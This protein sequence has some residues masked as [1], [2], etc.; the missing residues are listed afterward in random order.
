LAKG[1]TDITSLLY[2]YLFMHA[3]PSFFRVFPL[4]MAL[5]LLPSLSIAQDAVQELLAKLAVEKTDTGRVLLMVDISFEL[6]G[7]DNVQA[8][9]YAQDALNLATGNKVGTTQGGVGQQNL[10][11]AQPMNK[12]MW[13]AQATALNALGVICDDDGE[14]Q[15]ALKYFRQAGEIRNEL[16]DKKGVASVYNNMAGSFESTSQDD[17][18][19]HYAKRSLDMVIAAA[20]TAR[21]ARAEYALATKLEQKRDYKAAQKHINSALKHYQHL[22]DIPG[23]ARAHTALANVMLER[24]LME[25]ALVSYKTAMELRESTDDSLEIAKSYRDY[26]SILEDK[27]SDTAGYL[28]SGYYLRAIEILS[29]LGETYQVAVTKYNMAEG[30]SERKDYPYALKLLE[31]AEAE[32]VAGND[33]TQLMLFYETKSDVL[34]DLG[35]LREAEKLIQAYHTIAQELGDTKFMIKSLKDRSKIAADRKDYLTAYKLRKEYADLMEDYYRAE[36]SKKFSDQQAQAIDENKQ[37]EIDKKEK[38]LLIK[39]AQLVKDREQRNKILGGSALL[40]LLTLGLWSRSAARKR[41]NTALSSKNA[42]I[43]AERQRADDLLGNILPEATAREL[44]ANQSVKPVRYDSVS[45]LFTD[46]KGFTEV[47]SLLAPEVLVEELD[48][49]FRIMD[50]IVTEHGVE[51]IKTIGDAYMCVGGLPEPCADHAERT[52]RAALQM[53]KAL[54]QRMLANAAAGRPVFQMRLGI[55][56]GPVVAGV[57]GSR[58]FAYDIWGDTV[59]IAARM[60]SSGRAGEVNISEATY[61]AIQHAFDCTPRGKVAAKSLGEIEMYFVVGERSA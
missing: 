42:E 53:Q 37:I 46:F 58:K 11:K 49:C 22:G 6:I 24:D 30:A 38:E 9:K 23:Q 47:A 43:E 48:Q 36:E 56:T 2:N 17:S 15:N 35:R 60:E 3:I 27:G 57:V 16:G 33:K 32:I 50:A 18:S 20:D 19:I 1:A 34:H 12:H 8:R 54:A 5:S 7:T 51:K 61:R 40:G 25:P 10:P 29:R 39:E 41:A 55:H 52:V 59:N 14:Y 26:A 13:K 45:V 44:K 4:V 31:E 21:M 28:V